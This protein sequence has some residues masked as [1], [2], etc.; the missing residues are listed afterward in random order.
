MKYIVD[1]DALKDCLDLLPSSHSD[2]GC[3]DLHDVKRLIDKFPKEG[4][5][6][7]NKLARWIYWDGWRGN[8]AQ[9]IDD[10]VCSE[11]GYKHP[12]VWWVK[13]DK[14]D[15]TPDKLASVCPNCKSIMDKWGNKV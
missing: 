6:N 14:H 1:I 5:D 8:T 7:Q 15:T 13:G 10:A 4:V 9:R 2:V 12:T 11:C 3:V